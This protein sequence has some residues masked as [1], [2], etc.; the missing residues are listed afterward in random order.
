MNF[1]SFSTANQ[2]LHNWVKVFRKRQT[3][4]KKSIELE[5]FSLRMS[6]GCLEREKELAIQ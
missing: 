2:V 4:I 3:N 1:I 5:N 6:F